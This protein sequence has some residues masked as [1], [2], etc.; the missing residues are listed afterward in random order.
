[1]P[2]NPG[3]A[4]DTRGRPRR[5]ACRRIVPQKI[6]RPARACTHWVRV[7]RWGKSPPLQAQARRH[8][9]PHRVQGQIG[10]PG[11]ARSIFRFGGMGPGYWL[12]RQMI[13][14]RHRAC[15]AAADRIRLTA[16]PGSWPRAG[17]PIVRYQRILRGVYFAI[18]SMVS[19]R[20]WGASSSASTAGT[21]VWVSSVAGRWSVTWSSALWNLTLTILLMPCSCMVTP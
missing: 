16:L 6:N 1:M 20:L 19:S 10:D 21:V 18:T 2:R 17:D 11:A 13:L 12:L 9:K 14:S 5:E 4:G 3:L 15:T 8:G 7:K